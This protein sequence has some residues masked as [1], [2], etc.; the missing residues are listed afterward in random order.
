MTYPKRNFLFLNV[1]HLL[2]HF[3]M[4]IFTT[5]VL[6]MESEFAD[7][8]GRLLLLTTWSFF[9]FGGASLPA[10]WLGDKW[11]K[12]GM[13]LVFFF[14]IGTASIL[15]GF[16][17]TPLHVE[18]GLALVGVF[19]AIYHPVG[20]AM[21]VSD[22]ARVGRALAINGVWG[23]MGVA[24]AA[25]VTGAIAELYGWR[26]AFILPG[27]ISI[28]IGA[29]YAF[30]LMAE[31]PDATSAA[32]KK[33]MSAIPV[34]V[35]KRA[36]L[37]LIIAPLLGG[38]IFNATTISLPKIMDERLNSL[39]EGTSEIGM[40]TAIV[41]ACAALAQLV[42]GEL[43]DR[44]STKKIYVFLLVSQLAMCT[45]AI[46]AAGWNSVFIALP[47]MLATFGIIP[48]NDWIVAH[49]ISSEFRSRVYAVKSVLAL[50]IGAIAVQVTGRLHEQ[51]GSFD[52]LFIVMAGCAAT[53]LI[54][55]LF[56][57]PARRSA[58]H[59]TAAAE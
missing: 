19:A 36:F 1:G 18:I 10:G 52:A 57:I 2:D 34:A 15:T 48:V 41:F 17:E 14:G 43:L 30:H 26:A 39:F 20:L 45:F 4:L 40:I 21:V 5:A 3:F 37:F 13:M 46:T 7:S 49:F 50:G 59:G 44:Y 47:L 25:L 28:V 33:A 42:V 9:F 32:K 27:V 51:T 22:A 29:L 6:T 12:P 58:E 54:A 16:S 8:Y 56:L 38:L 24:L 11:S 35:Q 53:V 55:A 23:N 31:N